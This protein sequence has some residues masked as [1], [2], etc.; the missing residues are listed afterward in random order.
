[1]DA[2]LQGAGST[3]GGEETAMNLRT[4]QQKAVEARGNVVVVAGAGTGKTR[5]LVERCLHCL[6]YEKP[7]INIDEMLLVTFTEAAAAEMRERIQKRIEERATS[8]PADEHWQQ[9]LALIE[10]AHIGTLHGFCLKLVREHF[11]ELGLDPQLSVLPEAESKLLASEILTDLLKVHYS[12]TTQLNQKVRELIQMQGGARGEDA[13]RATVMKLHEYSQS[14]ANPAQWLD[15]Q[16]AMFSLEAP[17]LWREWY[18]RAFNDWCSEWLPLFEQFAH[19]D[20]NQIAE[21][22]AAALA[23]VAQCAANDSIQICLEEVQ[24]AFNDCPRGK[25]GTWVDPLE[26]CRE[27]VTYLRALLPTGGVDPLLQDWQWVR[28]SATVCIRL[29]QEFETSYAA[30]KRQAGALDFHD[31]E[32]RALDLLWNRSTSL[33]TELA[34]ACRRS[35]RFVFVDEYQ[36]INEAQDRIVT[37]VGREG[38]AANRFLVGDIK[39]SIYRFRLASPRIF[40]NYVK[41][42]RGGNGVAVPL[43]ENFRSREGILNFVNAL[44]SQIMVP[45][46]GGV[47]YDSEALLQF[48]AAPEREALS[49]SR[50][51]RPRVE[52]QLRI[53]SKA[54]S[55]DEEEPDSPPGLDEAALE[56][57]SVAHRLSGL[58]R[59]GHLVWDDAS[60]AERTVR[61]SDMAILLRARKGKTEVFARE[62]ERLG[63]PLHVERGGFYESAEIFDLVSLLEVL[64]NPYQDIPVLAVLRSPLVGMTADELAAIRLGRTRCSFW[65]ALRQWHTTKSDERDHW[66]TA[67][68]RRKVARFLLRFSSWRQLVRRASLASCLGTILSDSAYDTWLL[69]QDQGPQRYA[70]VQRLIAMAREFDGFQ[71]Q[72]L[73]RFLNYLKAQRDLESEPDVPARADSDA[74]RV[75]SIHQ[76]KGLEFP[77]V[78]VAGLGRNFNQRD[79]QE[80]LLFDEEFGVCTTVRPPHSRSRYPSLPL[81]MSRQRQRKELRGEELRLLYVALTRA[82]DTLILTGSVTEN[83]L[84][85]WREAE[86]ISPRDLIEAKSAAEWIGIW[87]AQ[88]YPGDAWQGTCQGSNH[89]VSWRIHDDADLSDQTDMI[90]LL[91]TN[92]PIPEN[93]NWDQVVSSLEWSYPFKSACDQHA[94]T[95]VSALRRAANAL[96]EESAMSTFPLPKQGRSA[97]SGAAETGTLHH[98]F[99]EKVDLGRC[100]SEE[101]IRTEVQRLLQEGVLAPNQEKGLDVP[102]LA[103]FWASDLGKTILAN[104]HSVRRELP[105]TFRLSASELPGAAPQA[106]P[107]EFVVVQGIV[108]LVFQGANGLTVVDFK[109]DAIEVSQVGQRGS[110]YA[111]QLRIYARAL[112]AIYGIPVSDCWLYFLKP[113][114]ALRV[115][116]LGLLSW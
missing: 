18:Q 40:Q 62:F 79:L 11:Y 22:C 3:C 44:F 52:I 111:S 58:H 108:D 68:T 91:P 101:E 53:K 47:A 23:R 9:Q 81:W 105:F 63:I 55:H 102:A 80:D 6:T 8:D 61:W 86:R 21:K 54:G 15:A 103:A 60:K 114:R 93:A 85:N 26:K 87:F 28:E 4:A 14:L 37:A 16:L 10:N 38:D 110:L 20:G 1:M 94:K 84:A 90:E 70:N 13:V 107:L 35:L 7:R 96:D 39:Q 64:D 25:K 95:T 49:A 71:A 76:S 48:G 32:Q 2:P 5:T 73:M 115:D 51:S 104:R 88:T 92:E 66:T 29:A 50:D 30:A 17:D 78:V 77:V 12:G 75:L 106:G 24:N 69:A 56:A 72:G 41:A 65:A 57:R 89:L 112:Q 19:R 42:W 34:L 74:V 99:L 67:E 82:R 100:G 98:L 31:L 43:Q 33:P 83:Q 45:A 36:D 27:Q 113:G 59:A 97:H 109:T 46:L 116:R